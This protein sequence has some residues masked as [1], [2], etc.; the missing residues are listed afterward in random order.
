MTIDISTAPKVRGPSG[1]LGKGTPGSRL[2][3]AW[4]WS[5]APLGRLSSPATLAAA[6]AGRPSL[7]AFARAFANVSAPGALGLSRDAITWLASKGSK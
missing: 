3:S 1:P 5:G 2:K 7:R 6:T 4:R